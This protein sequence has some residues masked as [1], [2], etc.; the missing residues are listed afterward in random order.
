[1]LEHRHAML[2]GAEM[3][4][5]GRVRFHLWAPAARCVELCL[6]TPGTTES[7]PPSLLPMTAKQTGWFSC[8]T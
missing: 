3:L 7:S 8:V 4:E 1:M 2:F 6:E 5:D